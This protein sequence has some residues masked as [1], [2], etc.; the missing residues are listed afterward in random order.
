MEQADNEALDNILTFLT[1]DYQQKVESFQLQIVCEAIE[2]KVIAQQLSV[3]TAEVIG[4][5]AHIL[6][7]HYDHNIAA[8]GTAEQLSRLRRGGFDV[9]KKFL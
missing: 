9:A 2:K 1:K 5:L 4:N 8:L 3:V 7:N 6:K